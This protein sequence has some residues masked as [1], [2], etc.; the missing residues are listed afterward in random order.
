M[1]VHQAGIVDRLAA[2]IRE[3]WYLISQ[4]TGGRLAFVLYAI[5]VGG[6]SF[7]NTWDFPIYLAVVGLSLIVWLAQQRGH[8]Q[9]ALRTGLLGTALLGAAGVALY[10]PFYATFQSQARGLL[11]NLWNPTRLPQFLVF[12]G[13]FLAAAVGLLLVV[14]G[15]DRFW[16]RNLGWALQLTVLGPVL[17][18][19]VALSAVLFTPAGR[20]Y[21]QGVLNNPE[22]QAVIGEATIGSLILNSLLR[23]L[24][25]PWTFLLLGSL[26]GWS[27]AL[28]VSFNERPAALQPGE[29]SRPVQFSLILLLVGL[30]LPLTVEFVYL[31]DNFGVRMNTIFKFY[32]Q[33]WVLLALASAFGIYYVSRNLRG[34]PALA[35]QA[36]M[37]LLMAAGLV[38]PALAIP[39]KA[40]NFQNEPTLNGIAWVA[41]ERPGDYAAIEWLRANTPEDAVILEA[42]GAPLNP[43]GGYNYSGRISAM[44]GR[45][46]LLGWGGHQWQWRGNYDEPSRREPDI[47]RLYNSSDPGQAQALLDRYNISYVY[48]GPLERERYSPQGLKKFDYFMDVVFEQ[49]DVIIYKRR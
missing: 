16:R 13:P 11:P 2:G 49:A 41:R 35:F 40:N 43:Y 42:P 27:L 17:L 31:R 20:E 37:V 33:A 8:W 15:Q 44:T 21:V 48:V 46:T 9:P 36:A 14:S 39:N 38:Y 47:D 10:L 12:F 4:A 45:P 24:A 26:L 19:L 5:F 28:L 7:L 18:M 25:N 22:V 32:F 3:S 34:L 6:L 1:A 30:A 23:R 29:I